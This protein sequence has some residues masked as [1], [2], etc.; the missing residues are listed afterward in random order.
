MGKLNMKLL[1]GVE[2][3]EQAIETSKAYQEEEAF[4]N[5]LRQGKSRKEAYEEIGREKTWASKTIKKIRETEPERLKGTAE[6][7]KDEAPAEQPE[8]KTPPQDTPQATQNHQIAPEPIK[9]EESTPAEEKA[10]E[11][12][13]TKQKKQVFSFRAT[14]EDIASWKAYATATGQTMENVG[15]A[16]MTE[17]LERHKLTGAEQAIFEAMKAKNEK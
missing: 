4:L 16:A 6:E 17:Y 3:Q 11:K 9:A 7:V 12:A 14:I 1:Q 15:T 8:T 10:E 5:L 2:E 13:N